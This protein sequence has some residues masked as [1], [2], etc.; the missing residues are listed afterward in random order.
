M[1]QDK[2][3]APPMTSLR[4]WNAGAVAE[5]VEVRFVLADTAEAKVWAA[6]LL[7]QTEDI[8]DAL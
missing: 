5:G 4:D 7:Q 8:A 6:W 2:T 3:T 1:S